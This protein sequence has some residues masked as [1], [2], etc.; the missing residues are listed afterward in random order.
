MIKRALY[1]S[2]TS[3]QRL[4]DEANALPLSHASNA[5]YLKSFYTF[6]SEQ[7]GRL[8]IL[9]SEAGVPSGLGKQLLPNLDLKWHQ[10]ALRTKTLAEWLTEAQNDQNIRN[11]SWASQRK[12]KI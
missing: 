11:N 10:V 6:R 8:D 2:D 4:A 3:R 9:S 12:F 1:S 7:D 5:A